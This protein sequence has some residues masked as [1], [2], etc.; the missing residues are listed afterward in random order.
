M[1]RELV[2]EDV[3]TTCSLDGIEIADDVG[4][5]DIGSGE[6]LD[7]ALIG[8]EP[9]DRCVIT[10][11]VE[12]ILSVLRDRSERIVVHFAAGDDG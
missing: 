9:R 10:G 4:D 2:A 7:V 8:V 12:K 6:L 3:P 11:F 5:G 1:H